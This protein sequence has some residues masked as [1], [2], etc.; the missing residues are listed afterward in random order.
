MSACWGRRH[1]TWLLVVVV[2]VCAAGPSPSYNDDALRDRIDSMLQV[3]PSST[4]STAPPVV[5][6]CQVEPPSSPSA[7]CSWSRPAITKSL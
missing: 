7:L 1:T 2:A 4:L 5:V 6:A 3:Q